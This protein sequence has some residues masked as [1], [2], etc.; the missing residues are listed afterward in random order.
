VA[1]ESPVELLVHIEASGAD[2]EEIDRLTRNLL[3]E[4][5]E[6]P[7]ESAEIPRAAPPP[8]TRSFGIEAL[9][10]LALQVV[11]SAL[12]KIVEFLR[13][14]LKRGDGKQL[15]IEASNGK[16]SFKVDLPAGELN[17]EELMELLAQLGAGGSG[18]AANRRGS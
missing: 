13:D 14:W 11:P 16:H 3:Q 17:H 15:K 8:G 2:A 1:E 18:P 4:L 9:G 6:L 12:P 10:A 7:I 5:R